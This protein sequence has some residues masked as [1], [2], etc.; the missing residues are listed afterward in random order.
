M[1]RVV[2]NYL[3]ATRTAPP[4][5]SLGRVA[6]AADSDDT[7]RGIVALVAPAIP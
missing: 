5:R 1:D 6:I 4:Q 2:L 3:G 7:T